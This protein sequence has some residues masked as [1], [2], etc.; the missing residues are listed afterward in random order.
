MNSKINIVRDT[1]EFFSVLDALPYGIML[2][3]PNGTIYFANKRLN[4]LSGWDKLCGTHCNHSLCKE[5]FKWNSIKN[6]E[7]LD[8]S[9]QDIIRK[10]G[11][12]ISVL[13]TAQVIILNYQ[14]YYLE[15]MVDITEQE[16]EEQKLWNQSLELKEIINKK[17]EA[18]QKALNEF[19]KFEQLFQEV[20]DAL[21]LHDLDGNFIKV[22]RKACERLGYSAEE[23]SQMNLSDFI[24]PENY[25]QAKKRISELL[26]KRH[27]VFETTHLTKS[28]KK[29]PVEVVA[30]LVQFDNKLAILSSARNLAVRKKY[31]QQ[32]IEARNEAEENKNELEAIFDKVPSCIVL[33]DDHFR[34]IRVNKMAVKTFGLDETAVKNQY[35]GNRESCASANKM[36]INCGCKG[37]CSKCELAEVLEKTLKQNQEFNKKEIQLCNYQQEREIVRTLLISTAILNKKGEKMYLAT[38]DDIT[39]RKQME[40]EL[41]SAKEKAEQSE[42]LKTAFLNN[43]SH[44]IRTPLNGILGF[45]D[46]FED[47]LDKKDR[48]HFIEIMRKSG[49]RLLNTVN[50][51]IEASKLDSGIVELYKERFNLEEAMNNFNIEITEKYFNP[52]VNYIFEIETSTTPLMVETD[53]SKLFQILTNLIDNAYKFTNE[54]HVKLSV[55]QEDST[56]IIEVEDSGKG[57][58]EED[59]EIIFEPFRQVDLLLSR[60]SEGNGLGLTISKRLINFLGGNLIVEDAEHKGTKFK[61]TIPNSLENRIKN[62]LSKE[63]N[64]NMNEILKGKKILIAE[65]DLSNY[66]FLKTVLTKAGCELMHAPDGKE[67]FNICNNGNTPDLVIMDLKMPVMD[68]FEATKKIREIH[69]NI[70]IIAHSA[71]VLNHEKE[72]ALELG[73]SDFIPKPV[74]Q[75][76]LL[77]MVSKHLGF[78]ENPGEITIE[79]ANN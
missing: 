71:Y 17:N 79:A 52:A 61:C 43:I 41:I 73:C 56:L 64:K 8:I 21:F 42:K 53:R 76:E 33:F 24:Q 47:E 32:L 69:Q 77:K 25:E 5:E 14:K 10:D 60:S 27:I 78:L 68:G 62:D 7:K 11:T 46:F 9:K 29:I 20:S 2:T 22:N 38:I 4:E 31:E 30:K 48:E 66:L 40:Q 19:Q 55:K 35:F 37:S 54:G 45:I 34:V 75:K 15:V 49:D 59:R 23:F 13:K 3:Q 58:K 67:A 39:L 70:P 18:E 28:G 72:K 6:H 63:D 65:D 26:N 57:I 1:K 12:R 16:E 50:N 36:L 44:E 74:R 51:I